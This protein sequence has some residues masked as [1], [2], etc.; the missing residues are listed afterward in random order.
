MRVRSS[1]SERIDPGFECFVRR[2]RPC[3]KLTLYLQLECV[4]RNFGVWGVKVE[5]GRQLA[6]VNGQHDLDKTSHACG[7]LEVAYICFYGAD[8]QRRIPVFA[9]EFAK[10]ACF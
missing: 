7:S 3:P 1:P 4:E 2:C 8:E 9:K 6:V 10:G 5:A